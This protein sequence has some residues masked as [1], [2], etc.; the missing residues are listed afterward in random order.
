MT[1]QYLHDFI[2]LSKAAFH[3]DVTTASIDPSNSM[4]FFQALTKTKL[5]NL[6]SWHCLKEPPKIRKPSK[7]KAT[8]LEVSEDIVP[9]SW[10][11]FLGSYIFCY[12]SM[13]QIGI[14]TKQSTWHLYIF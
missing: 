6:N 14:F 2:A 7:L 3:N 8:K 12:F 13:N 5:A 11:T 9:Q 10:E 4:F 1:A